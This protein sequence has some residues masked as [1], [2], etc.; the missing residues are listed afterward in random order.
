[1]SES[2]LD[3]ETETQIIS[4]GCPAWAHEMI[5]RILLLEI[6]S[7]TFKSPTSDDASDGKSKG[8][9]TSNID[10][11]TKIANRLDRQG[12][13]NLSEEIETIFSRV[14]RGLVNDGFSL[15]Q[16][17]AMINSRIPTGCRLPYCSA[18]EIRDSLS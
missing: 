16:I 4:D 17:A 8:W 3:Q 6:E 14:A 18:A 5:A 11:L 7:G 15:E 1:M 9:A 2:T 13:Q 12:L 10:E